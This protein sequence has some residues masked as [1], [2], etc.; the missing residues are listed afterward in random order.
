LARRPEGS[1]RQRKFQSNAGTTSGCLS[2]ESDRKPERPVRA[3]TSP[4]RVVVA[5]HD[6]WPSPWRA[7]EAA[8]PVTGDQTSAE[9]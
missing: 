3:L 1:Q 5:A 9:C 2:P 4:Y 6:G 7:T 8:G